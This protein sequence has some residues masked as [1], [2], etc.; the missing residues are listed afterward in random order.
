ML[1][2]KMRSRLLAFLLPTF[3]ILAWWGVAFS[4]QTKT[5]S[6]LT[7]EKRMREAPL[8]SKHPLLQ[9]E[10]IQRALEGDFP[11]MVQLIAAW[12]LE[13][14]VLSPEKR[15]LLVDG[16]LAIQTKTK[17]KR[18]TYFPQTFLAAGLLLTLA[19]PSEIIALPKGFRR[20]GELYPP[21]LTELIKYDADVYHLETIQR[22]IAFVSPYSHPITIESLEKRGLQLVHLQTV[23]SLADLDLAINTVGDVIDAKEKAALL[24]TFIHSYL[25][26]TE[27]QLQSH[28]IEKK[29]LY[30]NYVTQF[31]YPPPH[32]LT[33]ELLQRLGLKLGNDAPLEVEDLLTLAPDYL[34]I[35]TQEK[36]S[37]QTL[38]NT[39]PGLKKSRL[40]KMATSMLSIKR[41][42]IHSPLLFFWAILISIPSWWRAQREDFSLYYFATLFTLAALYR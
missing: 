22:G 36:E 25:A 14:A 9:R 28:P 29:V 38:L 10:T 19:H 21:H 23:E 2:K 1:K 12:D 32:S 7:R 18:A 8:V 24:Q 37:L 17:I 26:A 4:S 31:T 30:L 39:N 5:A 16:L 42:K 6:P 3:F 27:Q 33:G 20:Q 40:C 11:L 34:I 41:S 35:A 13:K 15:I